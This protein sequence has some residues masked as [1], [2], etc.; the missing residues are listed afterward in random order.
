MEEIS[1]LYKQLEDSKKN[2]IVLAEELEL[3][4]KES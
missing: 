4:R 3:L 1:E 2:E